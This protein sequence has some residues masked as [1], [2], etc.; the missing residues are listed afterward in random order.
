MTTTIDYALMA[1]RAYQDTRDLTNRFPVPQGRAAFAH[2]PNNPEFPQITG[3]AGFEAIAFRKGTNI[4]ISYA[5]TYDK[6]ITGDIFA[7]IGLA[8]GVGSAQL[9]Q[10]AEY[11]LQVK[12]ANPTATSITFTGHSLGGGLAA[13][14]GVFFGQ[15]AVTFDQA[16]FARSAKLNVLTPDIAANLKTDLLASGHTE[17]DLSGLTD[18]LTLRAAMAIGEI[19]NSSLVDSINVA[20]EFLSGVPWNIPDRIGIPVNIPNSASGVSGTDLHSQALLTAFVQS[21]QTAASHQALNDVTFKLSDLMGMIFSRDLYRF[22]TDTANRNFLE[23]LVQNESGNAMVTRFTSD[24][25]KLAQEGGLTMADDPTAATKFV[26]KTLTAFAMQMYYE[27]TA[28]AT[29]A[30]KELFTEVTGGVQF[31]RADVSAALNDAKGYTLYF[32]NYLNSNAFTDP[33]RQLIQPMLPTLRDWYVQADK[34]NYEHSFER[35]AA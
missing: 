30:N 4:V 6:D 25:W 13:L 2:V 23:R 21:L 16:P 14:M 11:Y 32:Q 24:L 17:A 22:D 18:F 34:A 7:D 5:G 3:A 20:G 8:T 1:G 28:T 12:A 15:Q 35:S 9:L 31:D 27:D 29:N 19:P 26:S 10:A 33:E